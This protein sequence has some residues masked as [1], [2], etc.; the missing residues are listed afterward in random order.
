MRYLIPKVMRFPAQDNYYYQY[1][2]AQWLV[3]NLIYLYLKK[4]KFF[5]KLY[6]NIYIIKRLIMSPEVEKFIKE[7]ADLIN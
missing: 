5:A 6:V 3:P 1:Q 7:N 2:Q 4:V